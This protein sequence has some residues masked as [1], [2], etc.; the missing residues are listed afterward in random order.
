MGIVGM[1]AGVAGAIVGGL[2]AGHTS[3]MPSAA[4][5]GLLVTS[6]S[7]ILGLGVGMIIRHS[8]AAVSTVLIWAL[9]LEN[10]VKGFAPANASR[11]LPFSA[12]I[13]L[14]GIQSAGDSPATIAA[15]LTRPQD[16]VLYLAYA[17]AALAIGTV[18]LYRRDPH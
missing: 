9:V 11:W 12:A 2:D 18:L 10:L 3:G 15:Q 6:L 16:A 7:P 1:I 14:I 4:L 8:A 17:V 13:R 5:W